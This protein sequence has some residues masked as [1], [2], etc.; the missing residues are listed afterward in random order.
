MMRVLVL[1][2][3]GFVG[4]HVVRSLT[5]S[6]WATPISGSRR[7]VAGRGGEAIALDARD[8]AAVAS[9]LQGVDAVVNCVAGDAE[10]IVQN[11]RA[12][13]QAA[14]KTGAHVVHLSSMAVYGDAT[15]P[16]DEDAP[17][18]GNVSDYAAAK[19]RAEALAGGRATIFRPGCIY[20]SD[21]PQWTL[22]I[23]RLLLE[24]RIGDL[25]AAG[26]GCS[27]LVHVQDVAAAVLAALRDARTGAYNLVMPQAPDWNEYFLQFARAIGAVPIGR[28]PEWRLKLETKLLAPPLKIAELVAARVSR[29][30]S[31]PPPIPPSLA[32]L[33]RQ[34]IRLNS[35]RATRELGML[36]TS[37]DA[38]L[39]EAA[40]CC[41]ATRLR[42]SL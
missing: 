18:L 13:F 29:T 25:A 10:G 37:L 16:V 24:R 23:A 34:D 11:A 3:N 14:A 26:D 1:G 31:L 15:G 30:A 12:L 41:Q 7:A 38:G 4:R 21:S 42:V 22:R 28:I 5:A 2:G 17:L 20:G 19:V 8:E 39:A 33:W 9:G 32:R 36:W 35:D 6:G 40:Q 27:N